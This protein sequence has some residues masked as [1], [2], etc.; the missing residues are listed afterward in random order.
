MRHG[1]DAWVVDGRRVLLSDQQPEWSA[2]GR[3]FDER[4]D[5]PCVAHWVNAALVF[6]LHGDLLVA[7]SE[8]AV[9]VR[10]RSALRIGGILY[11]PWSLLCL[12]FRTG[13]GSARSLDNGSGLER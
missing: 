8:H 3:L 5:A 7:D 2:I 11:V 10:W 12:V 9:Q 6:D 13:R 4:P 1:D